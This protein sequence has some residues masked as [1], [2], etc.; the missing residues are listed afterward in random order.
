MARS[1]AKSD[2]HTHTSEQRDR[3]DRFEVETECRCDGSCSEICWF[4]LSEQERWL[5]E[6]APNDSA[7]EWVWM[8]DDKTRGPEGSSFLTAYN[9]VI[10]EGTGLAGDIWQQVWWD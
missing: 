9:T 1:G 7:I 6:G 5:D 3:Y 2:K 8:F 4:D 10:D